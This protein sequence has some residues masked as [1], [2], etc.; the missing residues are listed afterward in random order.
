MNK[1]AVR[2]LYQELPEL[3]NKGILN[4]ETVAKIRDYYGEIKSANK[5]SVALIICGTIGAFLIGLGIILILA[6][7]WEQFSRLTRAILSFAPLVI[8]QALA[9]WVLLK[10]PQS[11]AL[12]E[13]AA[14]FLSL[15]VGASI[16]LISQTYN[17]PGDT[18]T[19]V[20][21]WMFLII[22][23]AYLMQA[24]L[25]AI[26]YLIGITFW[27]GS[28]WD[29]PD[30]TVLF[31]PLAALAVPHFIWTLRQNIYA[32]RSAIFAF[33]VVI[34]CSVGAGF[35]LGNSW[36]GSWVIVFPALYAIFYFL[37]SWKFS[38]ITTNWQR[39][40]RFI[41][42][43][44]L[45]IL[46]FQFTFRFVWQYLGTSNYGIAGESS[47]VSLLLS[48]FITVVIIAASVLLF[49]DNLKRRNTLIALAGAVPLLALAAYFLKSSILLPTLIFNAYLFSLSITF[50]ML[51]LR[52]NSL[53]N[54]NAGML[55]LAMLIIARF[56]DSDIS[57][58]IKGLIFIIV[59]IG[60]LS[61]NMLIMRRKRGA[62]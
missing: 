56:F 48:R 2:W 24:S 8:G 19:F 59:G 7:N 11:S 26:I 50:I 34:C 17:I 38:Q 39:P 16:A 47:G 62:E 5:T 14:T 61:I 22:P 41:G 36:P 23:L 58:I 27:S 45:F 31:W 40:L 6:H 13:G 33:V 60:F 46:A 54:V 57:F 55:M 28:F 1:R 49:Y 12:K 4:Q 9:I 10:R 15:M 37:G 43:V 53:A 44:G 30:K 20:M 52:K 51:G 21:T 18:G 42:A 35:S 29:N 25:P 32:I 3:I